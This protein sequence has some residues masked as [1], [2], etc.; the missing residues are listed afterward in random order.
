LPEKK[1]RIEIVPVI[2]IAPGAA[3]RQERC[4]FFNIWDPLNACPSFLNTQK[5]RT[6]YRNFR[7]AMKIA[8]PS[9]ANTGTRGSGDFWVGAVAGTRAAETV[10]VTPA[11]TGVVVM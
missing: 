11:F 4:T 1:D 8:N 9:A 7:L 5:K 6:G 2:A 10:L 3:P